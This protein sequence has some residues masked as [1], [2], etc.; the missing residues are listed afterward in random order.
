MDDDQLLTNKRIGIVIVFIGILITICYLLMLSHLENTSKIDF[1]LWDVNTCTAADYTVELRLPPAVYEDYLKNHTHQPFDELIW[2]NFEEHV[3]SLDQRL[4]K[5]VGDVKI[6]CVSFGYKNGDL[7]RL[8]YHRGTA[9]TNAKFDKM[10]DAEKKIEDMIK[11]KQAHL[12]VPVNAFITFETQE[13][14]DRCEFNLFHN[15]RHGKKNP[16]KKDTKILGHTCKVEKSGEPSDII[17]ENLQY[18]RAYMLRQRVYVFIAILVIIF[19]ISILF[20]VLKSQAGKNKLTYPGDVDCESIY[21]SYP[22]PE[23]GKN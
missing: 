3:N 12:E 14:Y 13:G 7:I 1:K 18:T 16:N 15:D 23:G 10:T 8:L 5:H 20:T 22:T 11:E 17:W 21:D 9:I 4:D 6:A 2:K 19:L